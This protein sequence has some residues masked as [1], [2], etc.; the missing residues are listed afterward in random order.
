MS[1]PRGTTAPTLAALETD[2][3][4]PPFALKGLGFAHKSEAGAVRLGVHDP[5]TETEMTGAQ[6]Y[7][8]EEM[9]SDGV[10]EM[11][12]G[13]RRDPV[14]GATLTLGLGGTNAE[15][16]DDTLTLI[17]P[18]GADEI[19]AALPRLRLWSLLDGWRGRPKADVPALIEALMQLQQMMQDT[20]SI[21]EIEIN[22]LILREKGA[23]AVDAVIWE[24]TE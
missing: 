11:I 10:A 5:A 22:P 1:V 2:G 21:N 18:V 4:P 3:L 24:D 15:L 16:L 19:E 7:L 20:P 6:G 8:L 17:L 14:Y 12:V 13:L 9:V 23:I